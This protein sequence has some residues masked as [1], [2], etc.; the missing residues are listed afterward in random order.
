[1]K[2]ISVFILLI[3]SFSL[4]AAKFPSTISLKYLSPKLS[5]LAVTAAMNDCIKRGYKV[6]VSLVGRSG[7][8]MAFIRNPLA[9]PHTV[10]VSQQKA[11]SSATFQTSTWSLRDRKDLANAPG[12][13]LI[14]GGL[15]ITIGGSFYGGIAVAGAI[16][17][18]DEACAKAGIEAIK[19]PLEFGSN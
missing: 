16:P 2:K 19:D 5:T 6:S 11:F 13:L 14:R 18:I 1:M 8:L 12:I 9:G 3:A 7:N 15:P 4:S 10:L 17:K